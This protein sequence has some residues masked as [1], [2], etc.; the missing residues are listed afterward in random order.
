MRTAGPGGPR[1]AG[2]PR[3]PPA[4]V[5][6]LVGIN[7]NPARK[8]REQVTQFARGLVLLPLSPQKMTRIVYKNSWSFSMFFRTIK[9][10]LLVIS[11]LRSRADI[12]RLAVSRLAFIEL[13]IS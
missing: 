13:A 1:K 10:F 6:S 11:P 8:L 2:R 12:S 5:S 4:A 7:I 3:P 9:E